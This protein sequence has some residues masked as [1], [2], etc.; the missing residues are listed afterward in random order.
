MEVTT[1]FVVLVPVVLGIVQA[2][3]LAGLPTRWAP[4]TAVLLGIAGAFLI[5]G[6]VFSG[7]VALQGIIAG[8]SAA[9]L[10]S[11]VS[12]TVAA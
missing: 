8:L 10:W 6:W 7:A 4:I 3:K 1:Q 5:G 12:S 9:G 2:I 11:G